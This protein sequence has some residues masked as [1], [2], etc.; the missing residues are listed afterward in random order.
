MVVLNVAAEMN[1]PTRKKL[2]QSYLRMMRNQGSPESIGR[3][4][5]IGLFTA[6]SIPF[7][8]QMMIAFPL[9]LVFKAAKV[10]ALLFT[11]VT[12]P[13]TIPLIYPLQCYVGSYLIGRPISY[14]FIHEAL[15]SL[16]EAPSFRLLMGLGAEIFL[17][18][19]A[20]GLFFGILTGFF[21]YLGMVSLV[22]NYRRRK[23]L[24]RKK[25]PW[26]AGRKVCE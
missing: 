17:S 26:S 6:F 24:R 1:L 9:A 5:A 13:V 21:G 12:N 23:A 16:I 3:G 14:G 15:L 25:Q 20:G 22:R 4:A 18:F 10:P 8:L 19:F 7:A 11:W 2:R